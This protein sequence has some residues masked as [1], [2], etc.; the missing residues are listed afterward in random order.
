MQIKPSGSICVFASASWGNKYESI[1]YGGN[2]PEYIYKEIDGK[3]IASEMQ[4]F[5]LKFVLFD[6]GQLCNLLV[7]VRMK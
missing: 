6:Y 5:V 4:D 7:L 2:I 1:V 3:D